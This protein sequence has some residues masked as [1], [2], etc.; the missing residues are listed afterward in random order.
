MRNTESFTPKKVAGSIEQQNIKIQCSDEDPKLSTAVRMNGVLSQNEIAAQLSVK[1][2][3]FQ[4]VVDLDS[5]D[6]DKLEEG[7]HYAQEHLMEKNI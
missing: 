1:G 6:L 7:I 2:D 4:F 5:V 3:D